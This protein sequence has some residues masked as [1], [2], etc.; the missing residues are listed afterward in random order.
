MKE[1]VEDL[2]PAVLECVEKLSKYFKQ[3]AAATW[4]ANDKMIFVWTFEQDGEP[5]QLHMLKT[6]NGGYALAAADFG[7]DGK[8]ANKWS[9]VNKGHFKAAKKIIC[10]T[11]GLKNIYDGIGGVDSLV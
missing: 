2:P 6:Q 7:Q 1:K 10:Q 5:V 3:D 11:A 9:K 8:L 4:D